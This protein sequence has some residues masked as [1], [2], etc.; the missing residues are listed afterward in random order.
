MTSHS[1]GFNTV[2]VKGAAAREEEG[3]RSPRFQLQGILKLLD[4]KPRDISF[5]IRS[6]FGI[7][8]SLIDSD[9]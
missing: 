8:C 1:T 5:R 3:Q 6:M 7:F 2:H 4:L 9:M